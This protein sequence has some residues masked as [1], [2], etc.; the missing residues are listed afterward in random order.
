MDLSLEISRVTFFD[1]H[2]QSIKITATQPTRYYKLPVLLC[3]VHSM[4]TNT[5]ANYYFTPDLE[6]N[7]SVFY[8]STNGSFLNIEKCIS[9]VP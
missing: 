1:V 4:Y 8:L 9:G 5:T 2:M 7:S 3:Q 6:N